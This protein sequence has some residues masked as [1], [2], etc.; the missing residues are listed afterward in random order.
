MY[1]VKT[2]GIVKMK[3][4]KGVKKCVLTKTITFEDYLKCIRDNC[5]ISRSQNTFRCKN[6]T[7]FTVKQTKIALSP[8][9]N[10]RYI[11]EDN[12]HTLPWGHYKIVSE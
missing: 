9:D 12:I 7:V 10:K 11:L 3:K 4:A 6:H 5:T 2:E 1:S 8:F